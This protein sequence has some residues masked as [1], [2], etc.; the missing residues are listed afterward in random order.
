MP[1]RVLW[2]FQSFRIQTDTTGTTCEETK[3]ERVPQNLPKNLESE[4]RWV[5]MIYRQATSGPSGGRESSMMAIFKWEEWKGEQLHS[6][7]F[8]HFFC[9]SECEKMKMPRSYRVSYDD[10][11]S[12]GASGTTMWGSHNVVEQCSW[13]LAHCQALCITTLQ[14]IADNIWKSNLR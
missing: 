8:I 2:N 10:E 14:F 9:F 13:L 5:R 4:R 7:S 11:H 3:R 6:D 12:T 1:V